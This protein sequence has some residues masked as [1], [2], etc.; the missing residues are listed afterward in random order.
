MWH[1]FRLGAGRAS[2]LDF[3]ER[4]ARLSTHAVGLKSARNL[5][6]SR[7]E[8][9]PTNTTIHMRGVPADTRS[10]LG[11]SALTIFSMEHSK[12]LIG[13][14]INLARMADIAARISPTFDCRI[15]GLPHGA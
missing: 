5:R 4:E 1:D 12:Q 2:A 3:H 6:R 13:M 9:D 11:H 15:A 14:V 7:L 8:D 10:G